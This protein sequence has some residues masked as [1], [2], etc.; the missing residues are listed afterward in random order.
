M[1]ER[2]TV[3]QL[4]VGSI[5]TLGAM[6]ILQ[7]FDSEYKNLQNNI[8]ITSSTLMDMKNVITSFSELEKEVIHLI[9][10][11]RF[12]TKNIDKSLEIL[13]KIIYNLRELLEDSNNLV[14]TFE[15]TMTY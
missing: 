1:A 15:K 5:P 7:Y 2:L 6:D 8:D 14:K 4:V 9:L 11:F 13:Q 12:D 10:T 3:N